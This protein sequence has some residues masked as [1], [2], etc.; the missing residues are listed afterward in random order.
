MN[1]IKPILK[2]AGGKRWLVPYLAPLVPQ[3]KRLVEPFA[4]GLSVSF[5]LSP[6]QAW[7]NDINPYVINFYLQVSEGLNIEHVL[8]DGLGQDILQEWESSLE[9]FYFQQEFRKN[10]V[11]IDNV[12]SLS[13][14]F[15]F[16]FAADKQL[17][18]T[19]DQK[20]FLNNQTFYYAVRSLF[21]QLSEDKKLERACLFY[22]LNKTGFNGLCRFNSKGQFNVPFG[23]YKTINYRYQFDE[24]QNILKQWK[25]TVCDFDQMNIDKNDFV[26][27]DPPYDTEFTKYSSEDFNFEDQKR[28]IKYLNSLDNPIIISNQE[29][30]RIKQ[31]YMENDFTL[32]R[33]PVK[34]SISSNP[35]TR[36]PVYE[37]L[38]FKNVNKLPVGLE[39]SN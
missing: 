33:I 21:N 37:I 5:G 12:N 10:K 13:D 28:L 38:A 20:T 17:M 16:L 31:L 15:K 9:E 34:R 19:Y 22:F 26:Y 4:G 36:K 8:S 23:S 24:Y 32:F 2:W 29:T 1:S 25:F 14:D 30:D 7:V 3:D 27:A 18:K 6:K 11:K 35:D 39:S